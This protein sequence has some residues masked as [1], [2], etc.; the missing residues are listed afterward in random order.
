[1]IHFWPCL[2]TITA[3]AFSGC[4]EGV[5]SLLPAMVSRVAEH[6]SRVPGLGSRGMWAQWLQLPNSG[7]HALRYMCLAVP[8]KD[9]TVSLA[10]AGRLI[11]TEPPANLISLF[12]SAVLS[13]FIYL[14]IQKNI[15]S[16]YF[17]TST[18]QSTRHKDRKT[19]LKEL[20]IEALSVSHS[21]S[22]TPWTV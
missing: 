13:P 19:N 15:R 14:L 20:R 17:M 18:M 1:M 8:I 7:A 9:R 22:V 10:L 11:T 2:V 6:G 12:V 16:M 5:P 21:V 4:G 3:R